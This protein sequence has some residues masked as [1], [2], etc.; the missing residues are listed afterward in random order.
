MKASRAELGIRKADFNA[1]VDV[2]QVAMDARQMPFRDQNR[3]L[4]LLAPVHRDIITRQRALAW[5]TALV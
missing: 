1:L 5:R 4:A 3:L 2:L